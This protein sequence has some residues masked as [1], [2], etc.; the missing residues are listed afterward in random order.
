MDDIEKETK[1]W[2]DEASE[3]SKRRKD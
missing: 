1:I 3:R 2:R